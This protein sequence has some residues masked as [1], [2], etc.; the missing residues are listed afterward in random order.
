M[1]ATVAF[2]VQVLLKRLGNDRQLMTDLVEIFQEESPR[3]LESIADGIARND[4]DAVRSACHMLKGSL[5]YFG[6]AEAIELASSLEKQGKA[7]CLDGA[8]DKFRN[9]QEIVHSLL[10]ALPRLGD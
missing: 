9:L 8:A 3:N 1:P 5:S 2:D 4:P 7:G 6:V 10:E